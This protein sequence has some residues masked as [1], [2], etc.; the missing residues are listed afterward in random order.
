MC[1]LDIIYSAQN[2]SSQSEFREVGAGVSLGS[3]TSNPNTSHANFYLH[4]GSNA[5]PALQGLGVLEAILAKVHMAGPSQRQFSFL[6][7]IGDAPIYDVSFRNATNEISSIIN[8]V[9]RVAQDSEAWGL[10]S[11]GTHNLRIIFIFN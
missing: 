5:V 11:I 3:L 8:S 9:L 7:G 6:S 2:I 4:I 1:F 10:G